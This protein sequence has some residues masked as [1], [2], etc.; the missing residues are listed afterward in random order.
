M[1]LREDAKELSLFCGSKRNAREPKKNRKY[2]S[3]GRHQNEHIGYSGALDVVNSLHEIRYDR[4]G[5]HAL[6]KRQYPQ[7]GKVHR[8]IENGHEQDGS[9]DRVWDCALRALQFPAN[10]TDVIVAGIVID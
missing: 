6:L 7:N 2:R 9:D 3:E 10:Q 5:V 8:Y 1:Y 4:A